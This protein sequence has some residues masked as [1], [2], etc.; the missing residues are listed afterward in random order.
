MKNRSASGKAGQGKA[1]QGM[2][3]ERERERERERDSRGRTN[4]TA[5]HRLAIQ[6]PKPCLLSPLL[7]T[8]LLGDGEELE[9]QVLQVLQIHL[10]PARVPAAALEEDLHLELEEVQHQLLVRLSCVRGWRR[11]WCVW[12]GQGQGVVEV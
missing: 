1:G 3:S 8:R 10:M 7:G 9:A 11:G 6:E 2:A 5:H 12:K 4:G